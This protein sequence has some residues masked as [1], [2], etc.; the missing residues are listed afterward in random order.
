[1]AKTDRLNWKSDDDI[2][3]LCEDR[4]M[5]SGQSLA[6]DSALSAPPPELSLLAAAVSLRPVYP[7][8]ISS[9]EVPNLTTQTASPLDTTGVTYVRNTFGFNG[10]GQTVAVID[11]GIA[12]DHYALGGG[13]G[14]NYRVVGGW[15]FAENDA[16]PYDDG[17][18]GFHGTHVAGII[19]SSDSRYSGVAPGVDLVAL[20][21]FDDQG[22][23]DFSKVEAALRW[24]HT[25][26]NAFESP[27][28][29]V[30]LS[31]G[32]SW[33]S[34]TNPS[35]AMLEDEFAQLKA[36]GIFISVSAGNS[37]EQFRAKGLSYPASSSNVVP[38]ASVDAN[39]QMSYFSQR[40]ERVIAAPGENIISTVPD[41][42][43][44]FDG[45]TNDFASASGT[46]MAAPFV[47]GASTL[48]RQAMQFA[49]QSNITEDTI[50]NHLRATADPIY[51]AVTRTTYFR[52]DVGAAIDA[53]MPT[54]EDGSTAA[55]SRSLGSLVGDTTIGG[56]LAKL[57]DQDF[58][59]FRA[60]VSGTVTLTADS[61]TSAMHWTTTAGGHINGET[62]TLQV[63]AG[64]TYTVGFA[65]N[66]SLAHYSVAIDVQGGTPVA[67]W[68]TVDFA[69][70]DHVAIGS[71]GAWFKVSAAR[72]G[73]FT[74]DAAFQT[75]RG[76]V[77][78]QL[79]DANTQPIGGVASMASSGAQRLD[80]GATAG[81]SF[82]VHVTGANSDVSLRVTN[83]VV[84]SGRTLSIYGGA[85]ADTIDYQGGTSALAIVNGVGYSFA[86]LNQTRIYG[87]NGQDQVIIRGTS[88]AETI[89]LAPTTATVSTASWRVTAEGAEQI[90]VIGNGGNDS[91]TL[92]DSAGDDSL[93]A[94]NFTATLSGAGYS[95]TSDGVGKVTI[96]ASTGND[97]AQLIGTAANDTYTLNLTKATM[98]SSS[99][100]FIA[101]GFDGVTARG[102]LGNDVANLSDT[103]G[104]DTLLATG[105]GVTL[106]SPSNRLTVEGVEQVNVAASRGVDTVDLRG[107]SG[108]ETL[109]T[110]PGRIEWQ[111]S[112]YRLVATNFETMTAS[113]GG[114]TDTASLHD[115]AGADT[116]TAGPGTATLRGR[117][118]QFS[119][120]DFDLIQAF[121]GGQSLDQ[122][123]LSDSA[124]NDTFTAQPRAA[125]LVGPG[126]NIQLQG[127]DR[128]R[129]TS[130]AGGLDSALFYDSARADTF[131][132]HPFDAEMAG[133][134]Y[135]HSA[136]GFA[137]I[138]AMSIA[139]GRDKANLYDS[140]GND[141]LASTAS[142]TTLR[143]QGFENTVNGF[144]TVKVVADGGGFN[145]AVFEAMSQ[146]DQ[147]RGR[148]NWA[149]A[150]RAG[151]VVTA[152]D[153]DAVQYSTEPGETPRA[154]ISAVDYLFEREGS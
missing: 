149:A 142:G 141:Q 148:L 13:L 93:V 4:R 110:R 98:A 2:F 37:F 21:V 105:G 64:Q 54:D 84:Q 14:A 152:Y 129:A 67:D 75:S 24:V 126:Y 61:A 74:V 44:S 19:G 125:S 7:T 68:G 3:E 81:Q 59:S 53:L 107:T 45:R 65:G 136:S 147:I 58:V 113:G 31:I 34:S 49:G 151:R 33:N 82:Y 128:V 46:S 139:G 35:W 27:I 88:G 63:Q 109:T 29:T 50:Y 118:Y 17:P 121:A 26:R 43:Y 122:A 127:F 130:T 134:G 12:W 100:Q 10:T 40:N 99:Y 60:M 92:R 48:V 132:S 66:G 56:H 30:N 25:N 77:Q 154:D 102:G 23:G 91:S 124:G 101:Q 15:D 87:G 78:I 104:N 138:S 145:A 51:D 112:G 143:G 32:T 80:I 71:E 115:S 11:T 103:T 117:T 116:L 6:D 20:R 76:N 1:M 57:N 97:Q 144:R 9:G 70:R 8:V 28:T 123:F 55:T 38:V 135:R 111:T 79:C 72:D 96:L 137:N 69:R 85:G 131:T 140:A 42:L 18:A 83:L 86:N 119:V 89:Q 95:I 73:Q 153:F 146:E 90:R 36:D 133:P 62:L 39:G 22:N 52:I 114:G 94:S 16:N 150:T 47:A 106:T 5:L 108:S 120:S 41:Y